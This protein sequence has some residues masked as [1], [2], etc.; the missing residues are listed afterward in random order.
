[1]HFSRKNII[2]GSGRGIK[3]KLPGLTGYD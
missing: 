1:V 3:S 2:G